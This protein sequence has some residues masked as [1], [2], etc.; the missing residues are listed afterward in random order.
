MYNICMMKN[1][2]FSVNEETIQQARRRAMSEN[3]SLNKLFREW[4][5]RYAS[6][7][8]ALENYQALM[9]RL[10]QVQAGRSFSRDEM[11]ERH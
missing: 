2:T 8:L 1:I 9:E 3:T 6:Q 11:N 7:P 10:D 4:L 5:E